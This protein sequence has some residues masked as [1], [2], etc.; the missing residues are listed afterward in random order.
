MPLH[1]SHLL[2]PLDVSCFRP[3]KRSYG[4]QIEDLIHM[5]VTHI[6]KLEF[7]CGFRKAFFAFIIEN[8]I[9]GSFAGAGLVPYDP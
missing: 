6:T 7:L 8:N 3:M 5:H 1:S 9:Q 4:R 2:Q